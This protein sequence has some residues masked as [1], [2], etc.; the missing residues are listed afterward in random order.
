MKKLLK[1][2]DIA[3]TFCAELRFFA[4]EHLIIYAYS[5]ETCLLGAAAGAAGIIE[6]NTILRT[7]TADFGGFVKNAGVAFFN[8]DVVGKDQVLKI[9]SQSITLE[10][11]SAVSGYTGAEK[12]HSNASF[13]ALTQVIRC[14][15][16]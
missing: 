15:G 9:V 10:H 14:K 6:Q 12:R 8:A 3:I 2:Y 7:N 4:A 5:L 1:T 13:L 11:S 16:F